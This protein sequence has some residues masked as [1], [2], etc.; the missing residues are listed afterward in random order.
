MPMQ[1]AGWRQPSSFGDCGFLEGDTIVSASILN[2]L[3]QALR[4]LRDCKDMKQYQVAKAAGITNGMLSAYETGRKRPSVETLEKILNTLGS[5]LNDLHNAL[6]VINGRPE[7]MK[8][9]GNGLDRGQPPPRPQSG[10]EHLERIHG[11]RDQ[12]LIEE[13]D[14]TFS[15]MLD[16]F[17]RLLRYLHDRMLGASR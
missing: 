8:R 10:E 4:W 2:G 13:E 14:R 9:R 5:D 12:V 15:E 11:R 6:Q 3:G 1:P 17:H 7:K 16:G